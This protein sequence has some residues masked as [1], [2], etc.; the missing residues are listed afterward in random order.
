[1]HTFRHGATEGAEGAIAPQKYGE[2]NLK[3]EGER[4]KGEE[5]EGKG[6]EKEGKE[7][8]EKEREHVR[9]YPILSWRNKN[10]VTRS[11]VGGMGVN[12]GGTGGHNIKCLPHYILS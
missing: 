6:E 10:C 12:P 1:M 3:K 11:Y 2:K 4:G 5:K 9:S 7:K 8:E